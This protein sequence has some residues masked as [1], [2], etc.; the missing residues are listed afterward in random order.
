MNNITQVMETEFKG[1]AGEMAWLMKEAKDIEKA[2]FAS[3]ASATVSGLASG[4]DAASFD[5]KLTK[6]EMQ[7][8]IGYIQQ[9][10]NF[11]D[12]VAVTQGDYYTN[13]EQVIFGSAASP[14]KRSDATE[15]IANRI[16]IFC[17]SSLTNFQ[18]ALELKDKYDNSELGVLVGGLTAQ[19]QIYG[20][21]MNNQQ[22][23]QGITLVEQFKKMINN[24]VV[25]Q[26]LYSANV[27]VWLLL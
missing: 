13:I 12:N 4:S 2:Y 1:F 7:N 14:T 5:T 9:V 8:A 15:S 18:K 11:F 10:K 26:G 20:A 17:E 19:R 3:D 6:T 25:A 27:A 16:K 23:T 24:E 21:N 22:L